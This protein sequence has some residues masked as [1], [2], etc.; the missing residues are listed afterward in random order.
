[1]FP[2][3]ISFYLRSFY[4]SK[5]WLIKLIEPPLDCVAA[6]NNLPHL[7]S[8]SIQQLRENEACALLKL[9]SVIL[10][11]SNLVA[12]RLSTIRTI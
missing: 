8:S 3:N 2:S 6:T 4:G 9:V 7:F 11:A 12:L 1:M 5:T 10:E